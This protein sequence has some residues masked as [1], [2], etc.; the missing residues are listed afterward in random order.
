MCILQNYIK[1]AKLFVLR[2][3]LILLDKLYFYDWHYYAKAASSYAKRRIWQIL[4]RVLHMMPPVACSIY[5]QLFVRVCAEI[6]L[7]Y[8]KTNAV[9]LPWHKNESLMHLPNT[10]FTKFWLY[11]FF[12]L[13]V[14]HFWFLRFFL[15][16]AFSCCKIFVALPIFVKFSW[17]IEFWFNFH[18]S[19]RNFLS[20][21]IC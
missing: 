1:I 3:D 12:L 19:M 7:R 8:C 5:M 17:G 13:F 21:G 18:F 20:F 6:H 14:K 15:F 4:V 2:F 9:L 16:L 10:I 11:S